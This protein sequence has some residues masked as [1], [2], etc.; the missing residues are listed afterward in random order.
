MLV[1]YPPVRGGGGI[2]QRIIVMSSSP[3][4]LR[5][6]GHRREVADIA[7]DDAQERDDRGLVG[8]N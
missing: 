2:P 3:P 5:M 7:V 8:G 6:T 4:E 1:G